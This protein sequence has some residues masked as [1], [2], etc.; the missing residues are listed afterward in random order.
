[1]VEAKLNP[2]IEAIAEYIPTKKWKDGETVFT[3]LARCALASDYDQ[4]RI[5][6]IRIRIE[7]EAY[8]YIQEHYKTGT[9]EGE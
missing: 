1:M 8:D 7:K 9:R 2:M 4:D 5:P 3:M 6:N